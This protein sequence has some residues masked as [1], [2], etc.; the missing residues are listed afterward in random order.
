MTATEALAEDEE[1][2]RCRDVAAYSE[3][4]VVDWRTQ[5]RLDLELAMRSGVA[6]VA[7]DCRRFELLKDCKLEGSYSFAGVSRKEDVIK[8]ETRDELAANL[9]LSGIQLSAGLDRGASIDLALVLVGKRSTTLATAARSHLV[10][11]RCSEATHFVRAATVGA[12]SVQKG[13]AGKASAVADI[14][15]AGISGKSSSERSSKTRDGSLM[16]CRASKPA[17]REPPEQCRA[18]VRLELVP[19]LD[20]EPEAD[21]SRGKAGFDPKENPCPEGMVLTEG[22]CTLAA[23]DPFLCDEEDEVSCKKQC[24][25][26]HAG[27][28]FNY[29]V[30]L[31][32]RARTEEDIQGVIAAANEACAGGILDG[33]YAS[34]FLYRKCRVAPKGSKCVRRDP[35][36]AA[37]LFAKSCEGGHGRSCAAMARELVWSAEP[38]KHAERI[39][40]LYDRSCALGYQPG[41]YDLSKLHLDGR[42]VPKDVVRG[43]QI[44]RRACVDGHTLSCTDLGDIYSEGRLISRD[45]ARA[46]TY[47]EMVCS[48]KRP[49]VCG[50]LAAIYDHGPEGFPKDPKRARAAYE[51]ACFP[52]PKSL[53]GPQGDACARLSEMY[54]EGVGGAVDEAEAARA[55][56]RACVQGHHCVKAAELFDTR[57]ASLLEE[58]CKRGIG[59]DACDALEK[60]DAQRARRIYEDKCKPDVPQSEA[61]ARLRKIPAQPARRR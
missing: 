30:F 1:P 15:D 31:I 9:P 39:T 20:G 24:D 8:L 47:Y 3:P 14:F 28:C 22:K 6:V 37:A 27:S 46:V 57:A 44:R 5:G 50:R 26:G 41:C 54:L 40:A 11:P 4:L 56:D 42:V 59:W 32:R 10:G 55:L 21:A 16:A 61:C 34:A 45:Y 13:S 17:D 35:D 12:F 51:M 25:A 23:V 43:I 33:C 2:P 48:P 18:A 36:K 29:A 58:G 60:R 53:N 52:A 49:Y 19:I 7:Y 38:T